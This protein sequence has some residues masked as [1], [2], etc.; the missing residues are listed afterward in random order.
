MCLSWSRKCGGGCGL[1]KRLLI[2][3]SFWLL[4]R[5]VTVIGGN[6][7]F[8]VNLT[9]ANKCSS[10]FCQLWLTMLFCYL[11]YR[12][13]SH[14]RLERNDSC[15]LLYYWP[16][17]GPSSRARLLDHIQVLLLGFA[18]TR[19]LSIKGGRCYCLQ[20]FHQFGTAICLPALQSDGVMLWPH[21]V[22]TA[23]WVPTCWLGCR[24]ARKR[25]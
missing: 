1:I 14:R 3:R 16:A 18:A 15:N 24:S 7:R 13:L 2:F 8:L 19:L 21:H 9:T 20:S 17:S 10:C 11:F 12:C 5:S 6:D 23:Q 4:G 25:W 22:F